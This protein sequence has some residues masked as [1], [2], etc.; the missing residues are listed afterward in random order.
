MKFPGQLQSVC[1][2]TE[3]LKPAGVTRQL[4]FIIKKTQVK[5]GVMNNQF[6]ARHKLEKRFQ[7]IFEQWFIGEKGF[8]D[9]VDFK[10]GSIDAALRVKVRMKLLITVLSI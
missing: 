7:D 1:Y 9:P 5:R 2:R 6:C 3:V 4:E 8:C 10:S